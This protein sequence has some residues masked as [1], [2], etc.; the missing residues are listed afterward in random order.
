L[1]I[2]AGTATQVCAAEG[3]P[4]NNEA[5]ATFTDSGLPLQPGGYSTLIHWGDGTSS[6]GQVMGSGNS[7]QVL[8]SHTY[9]SE[10][11]Y[12]IAVDISAP[13]GSPITVNSSATVGG[14]V[15]SL[16]REVLL[17]LPDA[18]GLNG[19]VGALH[20]GTS[21]DQ[22]SEAFWVSAEHRAIEVDQFYATFLH[23]AGDAAGR[24]AWISAML[25]GATES[26]VAIGFLVS[27]E[28]T[29][30]HPT[31]DS[32][33]RGLY[34]D[35]LR[36]VGEASGVNYWVVILEVGARTRAQVAYY[37][38]TSTEAYRQAIDDY[39]IE[40]LGR[41]ASAAEEQAYLTALLGG[42]ATPASITSVFLGSK[43]YLD[44]EL[45]RAC[46]MV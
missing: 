27:P 6:V 11:S 25:G 33:V 12:S 35:E 13:A 26:D 8:G 9:G 10:G 45:A 3:V 24:N 32:F 43:E 16:Y 19:W 46:L 21:R 14:F 17:R 18:N 41:S 31:S 23:H 42:K 44:R 4:L 38:L 7:F 40:F 29:A 30:A 28:Y 36:R 1:N 37:F 34:S 5:V 39:Y 22:V 20:S 2:L 15:T